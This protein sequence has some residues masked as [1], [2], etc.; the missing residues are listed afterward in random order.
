[1][2]TV[3]VALLCL[4]LL[5]AGGAAAEEVEV[6]IPAT[7]AILALQAAVRADDIAWF[8]AHLHLPV[9]YFGKTNRII[10]SKAWFLKHYAAVIGPE[11]KAAILAQD[12]HNY[13]K[14]YQGLMVGEGSHNIW[15]ED[16]GDP[17]AGIESG[18]RI[19]TINNGD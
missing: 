17:G 15:L 19:I 11:L 13:F 10:R 9:R 12:P 5:G 1:M 6:H 2:R 4:T 14:N 16:F 18:Y 7:E 8:T 3:A